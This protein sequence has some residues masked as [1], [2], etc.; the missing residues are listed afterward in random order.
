MQVKIFN[1]RHTCL[2]GA[3]IAFSIVAQAQSFLHP[4]ITFE[5]KFPAGSN[6]LEASYDNNRLEIVGLNEFVSYNRSSIQNGSSHLAIIAYMRQDQKENFYAVNRASVLGSVVRSYLKTRHGLNNLQFTFII[7]TD[8]SAANLVR[9]EYRPQSVR[10][11]ENQE[12]FYTLKPT[13]KE[14]IYAMANY[15]EIPYETDKR[16]KLMEMFPDG[17]NANETNESVRVEELLTRIS[18]LEKK[19]TQTAKV[20]GQTENSNAQTR[21][22]HF[23]SQHMNG[24][25]SQANS[26]PERAYS[27]QA[28]TTTQPERIY[29][30]Q[31]TTITQS[32]N[33][34]S[35]SDKITSQQVSASS[36]PVNG[37]SQP[38]N[39]SSQ[40]EGVNSQHQATNAQ[41][42]TVNS[43]SQPTIAYSQATNTQLQTATTQPQAA[44]SQPQAANT[45]PE[46]Q[47]YK[48][49]VAIK[50]NLLGL[51]GIVPPSTI[52]DPIFNLSIEFFY[53]KR[54]S[55][56]AEGFKA[57]IVDKSDINSQKWYKVSGA[58][59]ENRVYIGK[60]ESFNG[61]YFGL[62][63]LYGDFDI[64]DV[65]VDEK[66]K[67]GSFVGGGLSIGYSLPLYRGI[68]L[69]T[70]LRAG[71]RSDK[72]DTY[73]VNNGSF[74][75]S[76]SLENGEFG[77]TSYNISIS[78]RFGGYKRP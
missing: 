38:L 27:Q 17:N 43:Q 46:K 73:V 14:L 6:V 30:Q 70:G 25:S 3:F 2:I 53:A 37:S 62:Y 19:F 55:I 50:T 15:R 4:G 40:P 59:I 63:G 61:P 77:L 5:L 8:E 18:E 11:F 39:G 33:T 24:N 10:P 47:I 57:P 49:V 64:R 74:Y 67:T 13:Y 44:N 9:V 54:F 76:E 41:Y 35:Q 16:Q 12:I 31:A 66:G 42:Q 68:T 20:N 78:Y 32:A 21:V 56:S 22:E 34:Y 65:N 28:I 29:S 58:V 51:A 1:F 45:P 52:T 60:K 72:Y 69:E 26:Q 23:Q 7:R 36:H 71:Y 48:P 75:I